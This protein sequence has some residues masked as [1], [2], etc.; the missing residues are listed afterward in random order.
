[1]EPAAPPT[2]VAAEELHV[3]VF[4]LG[5]QRY[6]LPVALVREV[7][8][9]PALLELAGVAAGLC[10]L[11]NRRGAYIPVIA[12]RFLVGQPLQA[13]L[14]S[15]VVLVGERQPEVGLLVDRVSGVQRLSAAQT[16]GLD[17][18]SAGE[19]FDRVL[20]TDAGPVL[21]LHFPALL[22]LAPAVD[23]PAPR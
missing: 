18:R 17:R 9:L 15:Q 22:A 6:G 10:G 20:S 7:V 2:P 3:V 11:L 1:M 12:G 14:D 16:V 13:S 4:A 8:P 21:L 23:R 19:Y 5:P